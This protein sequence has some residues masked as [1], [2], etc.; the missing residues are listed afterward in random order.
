MSINKVVKIVMKKWDGKD[1]N[2]NF[3]FKIVRDFQCERQLEVKE[4]ISCPAS[5]HQN[6]YFNNVMWQRPEG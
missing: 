5:A 1:L 2:E 6:R 4:L 3:S